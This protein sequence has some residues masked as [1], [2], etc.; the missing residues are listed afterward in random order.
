MARLR[1][2]VEDTVEMEEAAAIML[3]VLPGSCQ[4]LCVQGN[5]GS[6]AYG[7]SNGGGGGGGAFGGGGQ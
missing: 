2:A 6:Y 7:G 4:H 1:T 5:D 3:D